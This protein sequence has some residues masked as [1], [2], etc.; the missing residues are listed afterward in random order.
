MP[1]QLILK[2][3][4]N[5]VYLHVINKY[6]KIKLGN[7]NI[8]KKVYSAIEVYKDT[9]FIQVSDGSLRGYKIKKNG[10]PD[11]LWQKPFF[12]RDNDDRNNED[13]DPSC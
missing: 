11:E 13:W 4:T 1:D 3:P 6:S 8:D 12:T 5:N 10:N 9:V 7:C 2:F